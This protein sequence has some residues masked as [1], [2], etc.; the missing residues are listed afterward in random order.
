MKKNNLKKLFAMVVMVLS[1]AVS[2][3]CVDNVHA[4]DKDGDIVIVI[5][6]GHGG[7]DPGKVSVTGTH[8]VDVNNAIAVAM[9]DELEK[10]SGVKVYMTKPDEEW[11]TNTGRAMVAVDLNADFLI[12]LHNNSGTDT[13]EGAIVYTSVAPLYS[14]ITADMGN[15]ILENLSELGIKNNGIQVR[16]S[17]QYVGED[18][19]TI[20]AEAIRGGVPAVLVEHCFLS[21][22]VDA[23]H[24]AHEDGSIDY[25]KTDAIGRANARAVATY[26]ELKENVIKVDK[27]DELFLEK[28]YSVRIEAKNPGSGNVTFSSSNTN[29]VTVDADG[30]AKAVNSGSATV[31]YKYEDGTEG[32]L[33]IVIKIPEQVIL[34]GAIDPTFYETSEAFEQIDVNNAFG[35]VIYSDGSVK[36]V[37]LD[38]VGTIDKA[39]VGIQ[40]IEISYGTL[41]GRLRVIYNSADYIP[42]VTSKE[43]IVETTQEETTIV[44]TKNVADEEG[45]SMEPSK[46]EGNKLNVKYI[47]ML[48]VGLV[49]VIILATII[50]FI[51]K[52]LSRKNRR[53]RRRY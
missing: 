1:V 16:N 30:L 32:N 17:T 12:C 8:E 15:Y 45:S 10:Y 51:E 27:D 46:E 40:D 35:N 52:R 43:E 21:N 11:S 20:M 2:G 7:H 28:G 47:I 34:S 53:T 41:K 26:F 37:V 48:A 42:E 23:L 6:A 24:V 36:K 33:N 14:T 38:N 44:E 3:M 31:T 9:K 19:Y 13:S 29:V 22:P 18:Y 5:D 39:Q 50:Y 25:E 4:K 49:A